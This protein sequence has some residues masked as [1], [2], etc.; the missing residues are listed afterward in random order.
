M[1]GKTLVHDI[2]GDTSGLT[3]KF[4]LALVNVSPRWHTQHGRLT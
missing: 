4:F 2:E 3:K 1:Y